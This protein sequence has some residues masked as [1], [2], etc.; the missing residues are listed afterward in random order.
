M[1]KSLLVNFKNNLSN[2]LFK[3]FMYL[4]NSIDNTSLYADLILSRMLKIGKIALVV[5]P[6]YLVLSSTVFAPDYK[7][8]YHKKELTDVKY[9]GPSHE[10]NNVLYHKPL[11]RLAQKNKKTGEIEAFCSAVVISD[12][13]AL[14]AGHC[15]IDENAEM[16]TDI[17]VFND[18]AEEITKCDAAGYENRPDL[19][20]LRGDFSM[21]NQVPVRSGDTFLQATS[22]Q[23]MACGY[24]HGSKKAFCETYQLSQI[25]GFSMAGTSVFIPGMSGGA[26]F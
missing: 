20:L 21:F 1:L 2:K 15:I 23:I 18:R 19:G 16:K 8:M 26:V 22:G 9:E 14:T 12:Q 5:L 13:Y 3:S 10:Y 6:V 7:A 24:P 25:D 4:S 17:I 11:I